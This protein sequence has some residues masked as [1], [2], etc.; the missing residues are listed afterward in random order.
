MGFSQAGSLLVGFEMLGHDVSVA[1]RRKFLLI[2]ILVMF[3]VRFCHQR[4]EA[5]QTLAGP[6][7]VDAIRAARLRRLVATTNGG[8]ISPPPI[9]E[10]GGGEN[11]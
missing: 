10:R 8:V 6:V 3:V 1:A 7:Q 4:E 9:P 11:S 2:V 5:A